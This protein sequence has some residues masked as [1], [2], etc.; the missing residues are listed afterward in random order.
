VSKQYRLA[1]VQNAGVLH[2]SPPVRKD[3]N[4]LLGKWQAVNRVYFVRKHPELSQLACY[5]SLLGQVCINLGRGV[6]GFDTG[7]LM[8]G[9]GNMVGLAY[10]AS[11]R[12]EQIGGLLK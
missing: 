3:R 4:Y 2:L 10:V 7:Y 9:W 11:G 8:R 12:L 5:W 1:V 6:I